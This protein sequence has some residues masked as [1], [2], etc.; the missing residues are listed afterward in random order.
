MRASIY[1]TTFLVWIS[2]SISSLHAGP[3]EGWY[4]AY[5]GMTIYTEY[6]TNGMQVKGLY[7]KN[8]IAWFKRKSGGVF[9]DNRGNTIRLNNNQLI[10]SERRKRA[11]LTF[12]PLK[13]DKPVNNHRGNELQP[14]LSSATTQNVTETPKITTKSN[15]SVVTPAP[16]ESPEVMI[17]TNLPEVNSNQIEGTWAVQGMDKKVFITETREGIKARFTDEFNWF[18]YERASDSNKY[19]NTDNEAYI[20]E[21]DHLIWKNKSDSKIIMLYKI[22]DDLSD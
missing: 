14:N 18:A 13:E 20:L 12:I 8:N 5:T 1:I 22:S 10:F 16:K 7:Q 21:K 11:K 2:T 17:K 3:I 4:N 6:Y 9:R 19:I 15:N